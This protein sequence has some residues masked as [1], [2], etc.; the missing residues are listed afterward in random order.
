MY[1]FGKMSTVAQLFL[2]LDFIRIEAEC[3]DSENE[4]ADAQ[5]EVDEVHH[6]V[7]SVT[8]TEEAHFV[9]G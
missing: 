1:G 3:C 7:T 8:T 4:L 5:T 9:V 2:N 6:W